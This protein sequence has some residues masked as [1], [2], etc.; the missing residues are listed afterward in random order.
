MHENPE[1]QRAGYNWFCQLLINEGPE[2]L[3]TVAAMAYLIFKGERLAEAE[4]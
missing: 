4:G 1:K 3:V 2:G